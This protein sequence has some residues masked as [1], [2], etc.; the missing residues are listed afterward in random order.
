MTYFHNEQNQLEKYEVLS[1]LQNRMERTDE[2]MIVK[3]KQRI[4]QPIRQREI[5]NE[6][7]K[8]KLSIYPAIHTHIA[9]RV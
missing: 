9:I 5:K 2:S 6:N 8:M 4:I 3:K 7:Y 1:G